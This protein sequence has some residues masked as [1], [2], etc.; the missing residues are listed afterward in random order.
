[1][2]KL[3][4]VLGIL[5]LV[6]LEAKAQQEVL[7]KDDFFEGK[8]VIN[9]DSSRK[10]IK[11]DS[12]IN[13][14]S[15]FWVN[16]MSYFYDKYE[17]DG[18]GYS[19]RNSVIKTNIKTNIEIINKRNSGEI[20]KSASTCRIIGLGLGVLGGVMV[21][22]NIKYP[23]LGTFDGGNKKALAAIITTAGISLNIAHIVEFHKASQ[24]LEHEQLVAKIEKE[25]F[26]LRLI[27]FEKRLNESSN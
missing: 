8:Q 16:K 15:I 9:V 5:T 2:K 11:L 26:E 6:S 17:Y 3:V 4:L 1:M 22:N 19:W 14:D 7:D 25:N 10:N 20:F 12:S 24:Q 27:E 23:S 18:G 13:K 21:Y